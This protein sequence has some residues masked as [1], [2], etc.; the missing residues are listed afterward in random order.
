MTMAAMSSCGRWAVDDATRSDGRAVGNVK[1]AGSDNN[2][3][4]Q[5]WVANV[6]MKAGGG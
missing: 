4:Q 2:G 3:K 1:R 5:D 6:A